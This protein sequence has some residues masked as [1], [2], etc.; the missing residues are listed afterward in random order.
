MQI[1]FSTLPHLP[2]LWS[3][4]LLD[5]DETGSEVVLV[6]GVYRGMR[7]R[8][9]SITYLIPGIVIEVSATFVETIIFLPGGREKILDCSEPESLANKGRT[10]EPL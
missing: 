3:A 9:V 5:M 10:M 7:A 1:P 2:F 6:L 8:P 4:L